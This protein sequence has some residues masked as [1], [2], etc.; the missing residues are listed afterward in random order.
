MQD[1]AVMQ[2]ILRELQNLSLKLQ[3]REMTPV[4]TNVHIQQTIIVLTAM[5]RSGG[6]SMKKAKQCLSVGLFKGVEL[7]EGRGEINATHLYDLVV[8]G[9]KKRL[10]ESNLVQKFKPL[11]KHFWPGKEELTLYGEE[12]VHSL[13]KLL[14]EAAGEALEQF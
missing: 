5:K 1:L 13:A 3:K 10:P 2:D 8:A 14:G 12:E 4:D 11:D 9:L 7:T 6:K